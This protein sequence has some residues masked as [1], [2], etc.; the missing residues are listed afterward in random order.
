[1]CTNGRDI[2]FHPD[3]VLQQKDEAVRFVLIH[4]ILHC[5]GDHMRR[6]GSRNPEGWNIACD[7]A[8][9]PIIKELHN[10]CFQLQLKNISIIYYYFKYPNNFNYIL[11][12]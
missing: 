6:R 8:I 1:M 3:F 11:R 10:K 9:N 7:Y 5:I 2:I 4:E 12:V